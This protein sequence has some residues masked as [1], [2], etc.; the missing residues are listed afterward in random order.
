MGVFLVGQWQGC[1]A[2]LGKTQIGPEDVREFVGGIALLWVL[3]RQWR[4]GLC[5]ST[6]DGQGRETALDVSSMHVYETSSA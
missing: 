6:E 3:T 2:R 5:G 1:S 4:E